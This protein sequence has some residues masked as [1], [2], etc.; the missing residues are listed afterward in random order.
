VDSFKETKRKRPR[1]R[2]AV[3]VPV[4]EFTSKKEHNSHFFQ[5]RLE[6]KFIKA[7]KK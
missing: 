3:T 2:V 6:E 4:T 7:Q 5:K 1:I